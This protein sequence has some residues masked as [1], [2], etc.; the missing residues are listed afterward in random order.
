MTVYAEWTGQ[1]TG[2]SMSGQLGFEA[3]A[4]LGHHASF[5]FATCTVLMMLYDYRVSRLFAWRNL[6]YLAAG[7]FLSTIIIG[8]INFKILRWQ[9]G[10]VDQVYAPNDP[11]EATFYEQFH[12]ERIA[13]F[14]L[15]ANRLG[16]LFTLVAIS[17]S[18]CSYL[19][20]RTLLLHYFGFAT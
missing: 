20:Y 17:W 5:Y 16:I 9:T 3:K 14:K 13:K 19:L 8:A 6:A 15:I 10:K 7:W 12:P 1:T 2:Q 18:V 4:N 11:F